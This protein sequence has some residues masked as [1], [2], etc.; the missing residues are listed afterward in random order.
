VWLTFL[1]GERFFARPAIAVAAAALVATS[2][3]FLY[4]LMNP[5]TDVPVTAA[6]TLALVSAVGR[7][8]GPAGEESSGPLVAGL[9]SA[10]AILI[11]PNLA[12]VALA[13]AGWLWLVRR[14]WGRFAA[15]CAPAILALGFFNASLY[16]SALISG[17]GTLSEVYAIGNAATNVKQFGAWLVATQTPAVLLSALY[18]AVPRAFPESPVPRPRVLCAACAGAIALAYL[19]YQPFDAWWYLRFLL[20]VW[21]IMMV[22]TAA[23]LDALCVR[24]RPV[25][26]V[27]L[28]AAIPAALCV[29]GV[30]VARAHSAFDIGRA[31]RRYV[32]VARFVADRTEGASVMIALRHSGTLR[33]YAGRL[34]LRFDQLDPAWL[35]RAVAFLQ[36]RGRHP[37]IV[38]EAGERALFQRRFGGSSEVGRLAWP[39]IGRLE[40]ADVHVF[41]PG[42][43][44]AAARPP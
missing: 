36:Q 14:D 29:N 24:A 42:D 8:P 1:L 4:Q 6:W 33:M 21:P 2:P 3:I 12:P 20:P 26:R 15:G 38:V 18:I 16:E 22:L 39:P 27:V 10:I 35:D 44:E 32:D 7:R 9:A 41:A 28:C 25:W 43:R 30:R 11:R 34:T 19:F 37:Y 31:E 23:S 5:M 40:S 17:Y 13:L